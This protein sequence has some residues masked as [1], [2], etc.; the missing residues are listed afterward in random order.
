MP[1]QFSSSPVASTLVEDEGVVSDDVD[2]I[3]TPIADVHA[4]RYKPQPM[5]RGGVPGLVDAHLGPH[6]RGPFGRG[7]CRRRVTM[8]AVR[9]DH[10]PPASWSLECWA[11]VRDDDPL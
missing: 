3:A 10:R 1:A 8:D 2:R 6:V 4:I 11:C 7:D 9:C 5:N